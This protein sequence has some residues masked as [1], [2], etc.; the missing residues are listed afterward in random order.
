VKGNVG[1]SIALNGAQTQIITAIV[2]AAAGPASAGN[3]FC[4]ALPPGAHRSSDHSRSPS[5]EA[6][7]T[8]A[9]GPDVVTPATEA[10][11]EVK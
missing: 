4:M 6:G 8:P 7:S 5:D 2:C 11:P 9:A 3:G 10:S 1:P